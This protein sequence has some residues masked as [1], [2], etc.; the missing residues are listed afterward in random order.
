MV[1]PTTARVA[2]T[3]RFLL[4]RSWRVIRSLSC[5]ISVFA[6][7]IFIGLEN[8][9]GQMW[10][11]NGLLL[12]YLL[13]APRWRWRRHIVSGFLAML[14]GGLLIHPERWNTSVLLALLNTLEAVIAGAFLRRRSSELPRLSDGRYLLRFTLLA[15]LLAPA[16]AGVLFV[17]LYSLWIRFWSWHAFFTWFTC[18]A[19]GIAVVTPALVAVMRSGLKIPGGWRNHWFC[20]MAVVAVTYSSFSQTRVPIIFLVYPVLAI[21]LFRLGLGWATLSTLLIAA[22]GGWF[23]A[24]GTGPFAKLAAITPIEPAVLLQLYLA[25]GTFIM[26]AASSVMDALKAT[27][28]RLREIVYLHDLVTENSRDVIVLADFDGRRNYVSASAAELAG[29]EHEELVSETRLDLV[30]PADRSRA[31]E[32]LRSLRAGGEGG[33]L[34]CRLL[35]E[36]GTYVWVE[37]NMRPV[38]DPT[39]GM[40]I[41]ILNVVRDISERKNAERDLR[42][43]NAV[44]E[45]LAITDPLTGVANRRRFDQC[46]TIEWRRGMREREPLSV[47]MLDAD[48]F[49]SYN[50][51]YGHIRG[52][53][54]LKQIAEAAMDVVTRPGDLIARIGGEEFAVI[55]PNTSADGAT[56]VAN[57]ICNAIRQRRLPHN[58]NPTGFVTISVGCATVLPAPRRHSNILLER[59]DA[60]LYA[61]KNAG[62]NLVRSASDPPVEALAAS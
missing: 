30:H 9:E 46:L 36:N 5:F 56:E 62:R 18:D 26:F 14:A 55:L 28:R 4:R 34:E 37:T 23:T 40:V 53:S 29:W 42:K 15:V 52:D 27:E 19:L 61:A 3:P 58:T 2:S 1:Q 31:A 7:T 54:C 12:A 44:L 25:S 49:K 59:A 50:D 17:A 22:V 57:R 24:H 20:P 41:G 16:S 33:L 32:M 47:L 48:W 10:F 38:R 39:T 43:T 51:T 8:S 21:V 6:A 35:H 13:V 60:A 11:A 45:S